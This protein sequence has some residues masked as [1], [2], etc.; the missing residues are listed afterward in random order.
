MITK[1]K[2]L[3]PKEIAESMRIVES[4]QDHWGSGYIGYSEE[5]SALDINSRLV[6]CD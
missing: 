6:D 4:W 5:V 1:E 2:N 3:S